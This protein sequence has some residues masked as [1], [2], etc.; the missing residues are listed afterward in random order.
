MLV[1]DF[2]AAWRISDA[3]DR[4]KGDANGKLDAGQFLGK[5][6]ILR[7]LHGF[8]DA[9]QFIRYA[10][11]I[12]RLA[13]ELTVETHPEMTALLR[14]AHGV[15]RVISW[16]SDAPEPPPEW[17]SELEI[18][19]LPRIFL[20][21]ARAISASVPYLRISREER[22]RARRSLPDIYFPDQRI[23]I[24]LIWRA[25][26]WN[27][28]RSM[29]LEDLLPLCRADCS[30]YSLQ[31]GLRH[32]EAIRVGRT[33]NLQN[34]SG[35]WRNL[36]ELAFMLSTMD[37]VITVDTVTAHLAGALAIPV[38]VLLPFRADWRWMLDRDDSP[39]YPTMRLFRQRRAGDWTHCVED[40][41]GYLREAIDSGTLPHTNSEPLPASDGNEEQTNRPP[42]VL[43]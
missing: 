7:C 16:G 34:L 19:D 24:G 38:W 43:P 8:G 1:G 10:P 35:R 21:S 2:E 40:V 6:L 25:G 12:R 30:F 5:R 32:E 15:D 22:R 27:S 20:V 26:D 18:M 41:A 17:D 39:W 14:R 42:M 9:V 3:I 11:Q 36:E 33:A 37:L 31:W 4:R 23:K 28:S 13:A 29:W